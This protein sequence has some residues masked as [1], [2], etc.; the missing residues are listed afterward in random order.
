MASAFRLLYVDDEP[1]LLEIGK[2][3]LEA[4]GEFIVDTLTSA[5]E[6]LLLLNTE[7]YDAIIADYQM[8]GMDGIQFLVE[9]RNRF[10]QIPFVL[11]TGRGREE[12]VIKALNAGADFYLQKGG[13]PKSQFAELTHKIRQAV[14]RSTAEQALLQN[15]IRY[16]T[17][18]QNASDIIR[19][20]DP[21]STIIYDSLSSEK[22][23]GYRFGSLI[24]KR[25]LDYIHP[26][27]LQRVQSDLDLVHCRK[28][29]GI[30]TEFRIRKE[31]GDYIWVESSAV[32]LIGVEG[33]D[34][35]VTTTRPINER[36]RVE[37][38]LRRSEANLKRAEEIGSSGSWEL[39]LNEKIVSGSEG[40]RI[41]YGFAE[42]Q[43][44]IEEMQKI[45]LPRYR[46]LLNNALK[47][48]IAG[49][50]PYNMEFKIKRQS[51][52]MVLDIHSLA[53]YDPVQNIVFGVIH[54][55]TDRKRTEQELLR[56][57]EELKTSY[58]QITAA[59]DDLRANLH[60]LTLQGQALRESEDRFRQIFENSPVGMT[61]VTP[62]F[63]FFSVNPAW[64][65][66]TGYSEKELLTM[67]FK[68][69]THPDHLS[70]DMEQ[71]RK[72]AA[73]TIPVYST[74][75]RY[76]RKDGSIL[77]GLLKVTTIRN[78][79]GVLSYFGAQIED[80]TERKQAEKALQT[81]EELFREVFNNASDAI[82]L[83]E[84]TAEGPGKYQLVNDTAARWLGYTREE[85]VTMSPYD[86]VP[87]NKYRKIMP[88]VVK[89][90]EVQNHASFESV[91]QRRD[92]SEYPVEI[93][94][95]L[96]LFNGKKVA[97]SIARDI[98][99]RKH[100]EEILRESSRKYAELFELG[101]EAIILIE[102]E[103]GAL[104][105]VN[106]AA[107]EM[108][109]Y[110][111]DLLL[112]MKNTDL[113]AE[114]EETKK[115][116]TETPQGMIRVPL[117]YHKRN[118]GTVFPVEIIGRFFSWNGRS[119]HIAAIRDITVQKRGEEELR[120]S[121]RKLNLLS[122]ITRHDIKN[123]LTILQGYLSI[124]EKNQ[125]DT[126]HI[127]YF[128]KI[129]AAAQR[130]S[131]MILFT[132]EYEEIGV[133][134]PVWQDARTL[135]DKAARE[136]SLGQIMVK[137]DL[138]HGTEIFADPLIV[139]VFYNLIDNAVRYGGKITTIRFTVQERDS[140]QIVVC[141]DNGEGVPAEDKE[142][143]FERGFGK[144]TGL[145]LSLS[146]E[147]LEITSITIRESGESGKGA[148][149]E[150]KVPNDRIRFNKE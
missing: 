66:M 77:V 49:K 7:R 63:R 41:L 8:P 14:R 131:A 75:K 48:L 132:K 143:I 73:G 69:I 13:D 130:I 18:F 44:T 22:I 122:G 125:T 135:I 43:V 15:E 35:I 57:N 2:L 118:N 140:D 36:K 84:M 12:I 19:I 98:T 147:I 134:T 88:E 116:T 10:G 61:L 79:E 1:S 33:V 115:I 111:R 23:L 121:N 104:L 103:T 82:F 100:T 78:Q 71:I 97:L 20:L 29:S 91:H 114:R 139:K 28:N 113:S 6:A 32:N 129:A 90:L 59:D 39:R 85:L 119:V 89:A 26:D 67:S 112:T 127:D 58:K 149:F 70:G 54:D 123:N 37:E 99:E 30:P 50:S 110:P 74:E 120:Q 46:P 136:V 117:R 142:L 107:C 80:I 17:L 72:L 137:N 62:D 83:H 55:I 4:E 40:A 94:T 31:N 81:S 68:D 25:A 65:S 128:Q 60:D 21:D 105:E 102:N 3:F 64:I 101:S 38:I 52:G 124:L 95:H 53:E 133:H 96:F 109:G 9:V 93:S 34:G 106:A 76:I 24:G 5:K 87:D 146:R 51:D 126:S 42:K 27:D 144:N 11:F 56:K 108:Y 150:I 92:G 16:R 138:P 148:R 45:P 86:I 145:G 141:E 47:D